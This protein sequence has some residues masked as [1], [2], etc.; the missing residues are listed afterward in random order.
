MPDTD[1]P[2]DKKLANAVDRMRRVQEAAK[3]NR[4]PESPERRLEDAAQSP[5][6][7]R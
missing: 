3:G 6:P 1:T 2:I 5:P 7:N 4:L